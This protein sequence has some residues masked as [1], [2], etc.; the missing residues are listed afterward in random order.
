MPDLSASQERLRHGVNQSRGVF[1]M[2]PYQVYQLYET[3]RPKS[4]AEVRRADEQLGRAAEGISSLWWGAAEFIGI[5]RRAPYQGQRHAKIASRPSL[6]A[7]LRA[8]V[9]CDQ[10]AVAC[11][12]ER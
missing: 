3:E 7:G 2:M 5:S 9:L 4:A 1:S 11:C 10:I 8:G 6:P 12:D